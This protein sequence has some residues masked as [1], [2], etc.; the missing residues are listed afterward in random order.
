MKPSKSIG[1][2]G[3][4]TIPS[5][6]AANFRIKG[7]LS[8]VYD[9]WK[10]KVVMGNAGRVKVGAWDK[11]GYV[12]ISLDS[13]VIIPIARCDEHHCGFE[14]LREI[15]LKRK[16]VPK[17]R[18]E[19][20]FAVGMNYIWRESVK[21]TM[22][23]FRR[24]RAY[25]GRNSIVRGANECRNYIANMD[26]FIAGTGSLSVDAEGLSPVG[27]YVVGKLEAIAR[28]VVAKRK[29]VFATAY[30]FIQWVCDGA[31]E[32]GRVIALDEESM[33][34]WDRE[35]LQ[36]EAGMDFERLAQ[37]FFSFKGIKNNFH[38]RLRAA[39]A[40]KGQYQFDRRDA[41]AFW[42]QLDAAMAEFHR[43]GQI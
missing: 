1:K 28:G 8:K 33:L 30:D 29:E 20:I 6:I 3:R 26:D 23:A 31:L 13:N 24:F 9:N 18:Y 43:L 35:V 5:A 32:T 40:D 27:R 17:E 41:T 16:L 38:N 11:V 37:V 12:L 15:Y 34:R 14:V 10:A 22:E 25:G 36:A 7:D 39:L 21:D 2:A 4:F 42:G 19:A